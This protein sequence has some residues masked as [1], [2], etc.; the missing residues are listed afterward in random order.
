MSVNLYGEDLVRKACEIAVVRFGSTFTDRKFSGAGFSSAFAEVAGVQIGLGQIW[1][2]A[3][4]S[5]RSDVS[6]AGDG[7]Y[8][9]L[10]GNRCI[11]STIQIL[12]YFF[13]AIGFVGSIAFAFL[14]AQVGI[15]G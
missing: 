14:C 13:A 2:S 5:G 7:S 6:K 11:P 15:G 10:R 9:V 8:Y 1:V 4:L 12:V 3:I